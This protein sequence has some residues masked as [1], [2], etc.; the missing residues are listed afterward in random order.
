MESKNGQIF[1][2]CHI[3]ISSFES[4]YTLWCAYIIM[5]NG[6]CEGGSQSNYVSC[7]CS[8]KIT[9]VALLCQQQY[10]EVYAPQEK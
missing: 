1:K 8:K 4:L 5:A 3:L 7:P 9:L 2:Y 6:R 10:K